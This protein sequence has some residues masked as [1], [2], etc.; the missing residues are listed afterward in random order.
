MTDMTMNERNNI[1]GL[2]SERELDEALHTWQVPP[3]SAGLTLRITAHAASVE[4]SERNPM[5][6]P[7]LRSAAA[8]LLAAGL[9]IF[10]GLMDTD[11]DNSTV[12]LTDYVFGQHVEE[13]LSL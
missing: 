5:I 2:L 11:T 1:Q 7:L 6:S 3:A 12:D 9:G 10:V 8:L 13:S 4:Q